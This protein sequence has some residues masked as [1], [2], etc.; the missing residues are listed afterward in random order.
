MKS[1]LGKQ[2][3][4]IKQDIV[5]VE[6]NWAMQRLGELSALFFKI[7]QVSGQT[8]NCFGQNGIFKSAELNQ[9]KWDVLG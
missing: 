2:I 6:M 5:L 1:Q 8:R 9:L 7:A 4:L 3:V